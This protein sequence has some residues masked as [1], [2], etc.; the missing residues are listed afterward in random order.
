MVGLG[1]SIENRLGQAR[2]INGW[3][4]RDVDESGEVFEAFGCLGMESGEVE[5]EGESG[6]TV[7]EVEVSW[8]VNVVGHI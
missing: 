2:E 6:G 4:T 5:E 8:D 7:G 1:F 3:Q